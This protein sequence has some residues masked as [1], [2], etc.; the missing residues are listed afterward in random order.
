MEKVLLYLYRNGKHGAT[1]D[2]THLTYDEVDK[3]FREVLCHWWDDFKIV[4][5]VFK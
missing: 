1:Q 5:E 3:L 4:R 2:V